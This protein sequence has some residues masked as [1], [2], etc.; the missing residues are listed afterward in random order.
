MTAPSS[1]ATPRLLATV[2]GELALN[3][4]TSASLYIAPTACFAAGLDSDFYDATYRTTDSVLLAPDDFNVAG[5][6]PYPCQGLQGTDSFYPYRVNESLWAAFVGTSHE[7]TPNPWPGG[8]WP[9]SLATAP[10]LS[11]PW[12]RYNPSGG[13]PA[14]APCVDLNGGFSE[15]PVVAPA[16]LGAPAAF[17]AVIDYLNEE[18]A[19]C[20]YACSADGFTWS[21]AALVR[22]PTGCRTPFGLIPLTPSE[23][24]RMRPEIIAWGAVNASQLDAPKSSLMWSFYTRNTASGYEA[25]QASITYLAW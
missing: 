21:S 24:T 19:G 8:K 14:A 1:R 11:G 17:H 15:N 16:P 10:A 6:W 9:V 13:P 25:F 7:E 22:T 3:T 12:T 2:G 4:P 5:P 18:G 23:A 20:G